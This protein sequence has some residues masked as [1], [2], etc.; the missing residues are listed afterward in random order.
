MVSEADKQPEACG[1]LT[2]PPPGGYA[3][4]FALFTTTPRRRGKTYLGLVIA[5]ARCAAVPTTGSA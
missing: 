2:E 5:S 3:P 4:R 1:Y